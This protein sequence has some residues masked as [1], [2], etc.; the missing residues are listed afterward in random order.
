MPGVAAS[1]DGSCLQC[2]S[3]Q[4]SFLLEGSHSAVLSLKG[5]SRSE[6]QGLFIKIKCPADGNLGDGGWG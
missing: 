2:S 5:T 3:P 4:P 1:V 6:Y